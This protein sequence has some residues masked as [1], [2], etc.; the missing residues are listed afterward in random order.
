MHT[1]SLNFNYDSVR[2]A[3]Q[4]VS[5]C[6]SAVVNK[7]KAIILK[8]WAA[9]SSLFCCTRARRNPQHR[10]NGPAFV[11]RS[12]N[13]LNLLQPGIV[14]GTFNLY[15]LNSAGSAQPLTA[16]ER[17]LRFLQLEEQVNAVIAAYSHGLVHH[18]QALAPALAP[19]AADVDFVCGLIKEYIQALPA[20]E[21]EKF[22]SKKPDKFNPLDAAMFIPVARLAIEKIVSRDEA[23]TNANCPVFMRKKVAK[24]KEFHQQYHVNGGNKKAIPTEAVLLASTLTHSPVFN[25]TLLEAI[26]KLFPEI[27][28]PPAA[29]S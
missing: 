11:I 10:A 9:I 15:S 13:D 17:Q 22:D 4:P 24:L 3:V 2:T 27:S 7:I 8:L 19:R 21:K 1:V 20:D 14:P 28:S 25:K 23:L 26:K 18:H 29:Q 5:R 6:C 12:G 16:E